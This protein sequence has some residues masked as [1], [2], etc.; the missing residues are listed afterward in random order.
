MVI[1]GIS[2]ISP[3]MALRVKTEV[4]QGVS[5][6]EF[7]STNCCHM[8]RESSLQ[9]ENSFLIFFGSREE[10][11]RTERETRS[12]PKPSSERSLS[13]LSVKC[14]SFMLCVAINNTTKCYCFLPRCTQQI[15]GCHCAF[16][17]F[18]TGKYHSQAVKFRLLVNLLKS[19]VSLD[20]L[21][22]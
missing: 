13:T 9:L 20:R 4:Y 5:C 1:Q 3:S 19:E 21:H 7:T 22:Q 2:C 11:K 8:S 16:T 6:V 10:Q 12:N 17:Q 14:F 15:Y 18:H